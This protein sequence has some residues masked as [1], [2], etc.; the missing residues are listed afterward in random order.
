MDRLVRWAVERGPLDAGE[1]VA[2]P[3][4][5]AKIAAAHKRAEARV[6]GQLAGMVGTA[7]SDGGLARILARGARRFVW[8]VGD[9]AAGWFCPD[10]QTVHC[11]SGGFGK[12][13]NENDGWGTRIR[14]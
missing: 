14:T 1:L 4:E 5:A 13:S 10:L 7:A 2:L 8:P 11:C 6:L 12:K 9:L 3:D